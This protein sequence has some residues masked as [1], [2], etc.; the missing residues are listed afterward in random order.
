MRKRIEVVYATHNSDKSPNLVGGLA[1]NLSVE[2]HDV[3]IREFLNEWQRMTGRRIHRFADMSIGVSHGNNVS[4]Y[5]ATFLNSYN[6]AKNGRIIEPIMFDVRLSDDW[7]YEA[8]D[9]EEAGIVKALQDGLT[10]FM[11]KGN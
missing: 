3:V 6:A 9:S 7:V 11:R 4:L 2:D 5:K 8:T 10:K 1:N